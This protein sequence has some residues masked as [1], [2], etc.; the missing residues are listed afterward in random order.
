M[1]NDRP[2]TSIP[3]LSETRP[4]FV[5]N[6]GG[7][8]LDRALVQHLRALRSEGALPYGL[9]I[10][11]AFFNV[12]G[13]ELLAG[14][15]GEVGKVRLLLGAE[16]VPEAV[17]PARL[18]GDPTEPE[19][20]R[21]Q[22]QHA[23]EQLGSG[24]KRSVD[25]LPFDD[26]TD[27]AIR[28]LLEALHGRK[29]ECRRYSR[30]FL[31][32]KAFLFRTVG[33]G[34]IVGS[35][36]L[37][38]AGLRTNLE[39]N[40]GQYADPVVAKVEQW[41]DR[42][43]DQA[44]PFDLAALF[45]RLMAEFPPYLI[46]LRT[47]LALY[48][49][50]LE[51]EAQESA[52]PGEIPVTTF[53]QHGIWRAMRILQQFGGVIIADGVGLGK[54][55]LAGEIIRR[56]RER[57]QRVLLV[58]PAALRDSTWKN[59]QD[60]FDIKIATVS[61]EELAADRHFGGNGDALG[62]FV[63]EYQL[64]VVD[65][66]HNYRNPDAPARA[67]ILRRLLMGK[68][69]DVVMLTATPVNNSLWDLYHVLR[70]FAKQDALLAD[71]G[72]LSIR[73]RFEDAMREDPFDL[74]P[75]VL[76]PI[77][78]ATTV[79]R[80]RQF[81]KKHY[82]NDLIKLPDG[83]QMPI[84]FPRPIPSTINYELDAVL[85]GFL[86]EV[87]AALSPATGKPDLTLARYQPENYP[88]GQARV[89]TD[90]AIVGLIRSGLL[91]RFESSCYAFARTLEKMVKEHD[92]FL[93]AL[94]NGYVVRKE[95][96]HEL[97]AASDDDEIEELLEESTAQTE[98]A[99]NFNV[100]ALRRDVR[101]DRAVL[102]RLRVKAAAVRPDTDPKLVMLL[103]ELARI[104]KEA[105]E[106]AVDEEERRRKQK[107]IVFSF[108]ADTVD[109]IEEFLRGATDRD[110]R[111]AVYRGRMVSVAG[112]DGRAGVSRKEAVWGFAPESAEAPPPRPGESSDRFDI[113]LATDV[114]AEGM[115][116]QQCRNI[117]NY[118]LPWNPMRLVQRHGRV[119]RI[120]SRHDRVYLR[121]YF[122]DDQLDRL[123]NLERRVRRKL[124]QAAASVGVE[125][126]PIVDG[127]ERDVSFAETRE[128]IE[129][130]RHN[131]PTLYEA[132]G[133]V[134]A[135][136]SG[137]EYRQELR[138]GLA[139]YG[140]QIAELP[141]KA[142]SGLAKGTQRGHFF[143]AQVGTRVYLRFVPL[144]DG[145][146]RSPIVKEIGT[147]LRIIECAESTPIVLP[148]DLKQTAHASWDA[149]R[150]DIFEAWT[151]ETDPANLQPKVSKFNRDLADF[152]R[153]NPPA[154][155]PQARFEAALDAI[156]APCSMREQNMLRAVFAAQH[157]NANV[158][159]RAVVEEVD[160]IGLEPFHA[161]KPLPP[162]DPAEVHLVCWMAV[163]DINAR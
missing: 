68:R 9:D 81:V 102:E 54:T 51:Q 44:E 50:E 92:L 138:R 152:L 118:D 110:P 14:S 124:A 162:I 95:L 156:E 66:A 121:T 6:Q 38:Y 128:E 77:I 134:G 35:S 13:F 76:Y 143:C 23:L 91:K 145:G 161:P 93:K 136:Q 30:H 1:P 24:L 61:Y 49:A 123:L 75:D 74:N 43:W 89:G 18:P 154:G 88:L 116:L 69:R 113:M 34:T 71:R 159:S 149:A 112:D 3:S 82:E 150:R 99:A 31:H 120:G 142:G 63:D 48:G 62:G 94:D 10:A 80:T 65:E 73:D 106:E 12:P 119:D 64:V 135:A 139:K 144:A 55:F 57:R 100:A 40:L 41:Y 7:N 151:F 45:D 87:E 130:L 39:L 111:L 20:T 83:R 8:T 125:V 32:A 16:P 97:S 157:A 90:L 70:Y 37:T 19:W 53:Q 25:L 21:R 148:A 133:T 78:D 107:V 160:K 85:P 114:L 4:L 60:R 140:D 146:H 153:A 11:T 86:D 47:L 67:G 104:A 103:E 27:R 122:P 28:L 132:G 163:E 17:T 141:W 98:P 33:G 137:E 29:I 96:L 46:Y 155:V 42:L 72:V 84:H 15:L 158:K 2:N 59:F 58:C 22:V 129:R 105:Q 56:Y 117:I 26:A 126:T 52:R 147:C 131:D 108:Y 5:D 36:N 115:N 127:S 109:W 101:H 79:K